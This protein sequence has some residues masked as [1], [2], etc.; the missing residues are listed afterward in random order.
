MHT[1]YTTYQTSLRLA[2]PVEERLYSSNLKLKIY[3]QSHCVWV[4]TGFL[5]LRVSEANCTS[6]LQRPESGANAIITSR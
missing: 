1:F 6:A 4:D 2:V 3:F 5:S